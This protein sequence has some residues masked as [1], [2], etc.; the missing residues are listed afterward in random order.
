MLHLM[1]WGLFCHTRWKLGQRG[2]LHLLPEHL[3][4]QFYS[5]LDKE[6]LAIVF[7]V[8]RFRQYLL[9]RHFSLL[10]D[11]KPLQYLFGEAWGIP[12]MASA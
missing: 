1:A 6:G 4:E 9:A 11:H 12:Q 2:P 8:T 5:Q 3:P 10:S 7:G